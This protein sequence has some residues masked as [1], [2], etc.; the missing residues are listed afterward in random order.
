[1]GGK[2]WHPSS[3]YGPRAL[4]R[5]PAPLQDF[6]MEW[7]TRSERESLKA[8]HVEGKGANRALV[9]AASAQPGAV[10]SV[11]S[12]QS[13]NPSEGSTPQVPTQ[14]KPTQAPVAKKPK[15]SGCSIGRTE[16]SSVALWV[17][18][19]VCGAFA[20]RRASA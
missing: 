19:L 2:G 16:S 4:T 20:R 14:M 5:D 1:Q 7:T 6:S 11:S 10:P 3:D 8:I 18:L 9:A 17:L 15:N 13:K 12:V